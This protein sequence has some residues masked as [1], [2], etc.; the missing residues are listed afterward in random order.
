MKKSDVEWHIVC[1]RHRVFNLPDG[2]LI[3]SKD[4]VNDLPVQEPYPGYWENPPA[5]LDAIGRFYWRQD[6]G[7][8]WVSEQLKQMI[9]EQEY[10]NL[11]RWKK[12]LLALERFFIG[13]PSA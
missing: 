2:V 3:A 5:D 12:C 13:T 4:T 7:L 10:E 1:S 11:P 8:S 6:H 9:Q